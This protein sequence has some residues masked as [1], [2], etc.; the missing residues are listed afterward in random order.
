MAAPRINEMDR[1]SDLDDVREFR[2]AGSAKIVPKDD[3]DDVVPLTPEQIAEKKRLRELCKEGKANLVKG[4]MFQDEQ[5]VERPRGHFNWPNKAPGVDD[6]DKAGLSNNPI[7]K[8]G[9]KL[10]QGSPECVCYL[11][12]PF[13]AWAEVGGYN[14]LLVD[15]QGAH[16]PTCLKQFFYVCTMGCGFYNTFMCIF[17]GERRAILRQK[18]KYGYY[19][20]SVGGWLSVA[21]DITRTQAVPLTSLVPP[22]TYPHTRT[23]KESIPTRLLSQGVLSPHVL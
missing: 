11:C 22:H 6:V 7:E 10:Y 20:H 23:T 21:I 4:N 5:I 8:W 18:L 13:I 19:D 12:C 3:G 2:R 9:G 14:A 16:L 15:S 17:Q 1:E